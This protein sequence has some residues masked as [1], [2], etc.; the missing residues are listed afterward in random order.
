MTKGRGND[1][2]AVRKDRGKEVREKR[3]R[4]RP[5]PTSVSLFPCL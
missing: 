4:D 2:V 5:Q 3:E 1:D